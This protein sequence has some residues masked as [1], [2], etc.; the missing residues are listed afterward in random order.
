MTVVPTL[1][2]A[3]ADNPPLRSIAAVS[4]TVVVLPFV[5]VS[6][7]HFCSGAFKLHARSTSLISAIRA[8][9]AATTTG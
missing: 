2:H 6:A 3:M 4:S 7:S 9:R 5:P 1:P 8:A